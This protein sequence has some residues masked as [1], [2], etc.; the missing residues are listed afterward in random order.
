MP[1]AARRSSPERAEEGSTRRIA[2]VVISVPDA[3]SARSSTSRL[4]VPPVPMIRREP[5]F[6]P[7]MIS[8]SS[9]IGSLT[10]TSLD[11][12]QYL[13]VVSRRELDPRPGHPAHDIA[14]DR[15]GDAGGRS[16]Y[17]RH[18]SVEPGCVEHVAGYVVC[19]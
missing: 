10:S 6:S 7:A 15:D 13:D 16:R 11:S 18:G 4:G 19:R 3:M 17:Q 9:V 1:C 14:V 12:G 2:T 5:N 8:G